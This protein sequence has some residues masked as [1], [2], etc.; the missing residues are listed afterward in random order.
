[1]IGIFI[2]DEIPKVNKQLVLGHSKINDGISGYFYF[3]ESDCADVCSV[4]KGSEF[5][6]VLDDTSGFGACLF[7]LNLELEQSNLL[8]QHNLHVKE[9]ALIDKDLHV[10]GN[11]VVDGNTEID[12]KTEIHDTL[13][14]D[15][16]IRGNANADIVGNLNVNGNIV[17]KATITGKSPNTSIFL[18][19]ANVA[20]ILGAAMS[21]APAPLQ[22]VQ[23]DMNNSI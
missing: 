3:R 11:T 18:N 14:V 15:N 4:D 17:S 23:V 9:S 7:I 21:G 10:K 2:L 19:P 6:G 12:G 22:A 8:L 20:M 1:M 13:T 5:F 16:N